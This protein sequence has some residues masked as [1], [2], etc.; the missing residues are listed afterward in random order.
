[1]D[2]SKVL[3]SVRRELADKDQQLQIALND[4]E[5]RNMIKCLNEQIADVTEAGGSQ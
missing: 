1:M 3:D 5:Q 2:E 4:A